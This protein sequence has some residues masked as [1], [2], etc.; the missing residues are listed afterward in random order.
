MLILEGSP[1][2]KLFTA[3]TVKF[4]EGDDEEQRE[5]TSTVQF[6]SRQGLAMDFE[7]MMVPEGERKETLY[8]VTLTGTARA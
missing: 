4:T 5:S 6:G 3:E 2:P 1:C 7:L 8:A